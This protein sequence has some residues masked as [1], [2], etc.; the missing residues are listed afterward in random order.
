MNSSTLKEKNFAE[1][2]L[3]K[4]VT[5]Q[6]I[7]CKECVIVLADKTT[8]E[9]I[10]IGKTKNPIKKI[11]GGYLSGYGS[12]TNKKINLNLLEENYIEKTIISW[13]PSEKSR[14]TQQELLKTYKKEH[15]NYPKW[16]IN[17]PKK[18]QNKP[19]PSQTTKPIKTQPTR[20]TTNNK[21]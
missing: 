14:I 6:H 3:L 19:K 17:K 7:P 10:Y 21:T 1:F 20:K 18:I 13:L 16:N 12:K 5:F 4:E 2:I 8:T 11:F 9:I 15:G